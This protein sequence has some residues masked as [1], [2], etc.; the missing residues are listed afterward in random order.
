MNH[1][2][3]VTIG[4][5]VWAAMSAPGHTLQERGCTDTTTLPYRLYRRGMLLEARDVQP[6][7]HCSASHDVSRHASAL[8]GA[9]DQRNI[10]VQPRSGACRPCCFLA[11][12]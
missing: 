4:N 3:Y 11:A 5:C 9:K 8:R 10:C 12:L 6:K 2:R 7:P 1:S